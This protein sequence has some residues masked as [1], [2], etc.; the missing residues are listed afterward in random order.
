MAGGC[1]VEFL[2]CA[3]LK[4]GIVGVEVH[5]VDVCPQDIGEFCAGEVV[6]HRWVEDSPGCQRVSG[7]A[8]SFLEACDP[9]AACM[10]VEGGGEHAIRAHE[11]DQVSAELQSRG[12][13][14]V[15]G[16][17]HDLPDPFGLADGGAF[18]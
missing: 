11:V 17:G 6:D 12:W 1:L 14:V 9:V 4:W 15:R 18:W 3:D 2:P 5:A 10:V 7:S 16:V 8:E 13:V